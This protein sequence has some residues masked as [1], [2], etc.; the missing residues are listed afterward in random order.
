MTTVAEQF[1]ETLDHGGPVLIDTVVD[2]QEL[3]IPPKVIVEMAKGFYTV[4]PEG[5]A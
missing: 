5:G 2:R 1:A 4:H 3:S